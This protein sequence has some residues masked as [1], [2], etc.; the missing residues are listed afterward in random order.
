MSNNTQA[1]F[2]FVVGNDVAMQFLVQTH[3]DTAKHTACLRSNPTIVEAEPL[4]NHAAKFNFVVNDSV[5]L[6][7]DIPHY[8][9]NER[10]M[11]CL[12]SN[13]QIVEVQVGSPVAPGW[14]YDGINFKRQ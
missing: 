9:S 11:A 2:V 5:E 6:S 1:K 8:P 14:T 3:P 13:P 7:L 12:R 4:E 10:W